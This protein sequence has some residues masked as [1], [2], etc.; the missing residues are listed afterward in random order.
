VSI[1]FR[2]PV[3]AEKLDFQMRWNYA[4]GMYIWNRGDILKT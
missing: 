1:L 3:E 4:E 2:N